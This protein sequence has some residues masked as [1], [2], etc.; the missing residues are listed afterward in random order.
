[1]KRGDFVF[2]Y[3]DWAYSCHKTT[4]KRV[5]LYIK[6]TKLLIRTK[7]IIHITT[8]NKERFKY[9]LKAVLHH[10]DISNNSKRISDLETFFGKKNSC[11]TRRLGKK[12]H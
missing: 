7:I 3:V 11:K 10:E 8:E 1:M 2:D 9:T 5:R 6:W 4:L 12:N